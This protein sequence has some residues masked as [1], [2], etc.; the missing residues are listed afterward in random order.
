MIMRKFMKCK[1][2]IAMV[3]VLVLA[4]MLADALGN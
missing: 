3:Q 1:Y 2:I 4:E